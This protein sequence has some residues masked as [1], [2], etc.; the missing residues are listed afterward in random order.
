MK[1]VPI[2]LITVCGLEDL[3]AHSVRSVTHVLSILDP[4]WPEPKSFWAY[5]PHHRTTLHFNDEI[6]PGAGLVLPQREHVQAILDF[7]RRL[8]SAGS[9]REEAHLLVHCHAGVSRST[10][11]LAILL[12]QWDPGLDED[13][14]FARILALRSQAWPNSLMISFADEL[15]GR[16]GRLSSALRHFHAQQLKRLPETEPFLRRH[17]RGREVDVAR[18]VAEVHEASQHV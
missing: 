15:L 2:S 3:A 4:D 16:G 11:A 5:D 6:E 9:Q 12:A 7:G 8:L 17:R 14:L 13:E 10:A 1:P 18:A